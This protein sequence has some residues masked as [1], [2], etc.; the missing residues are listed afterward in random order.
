MPTVMRSGPYRFYYFSHEPNEPP[1]IHVDRDEATAKF[2]LNSVRL[3]SNLR[4]PAH[5][6]RKIER[7]IR[8]HH[9]ELLEAWDDHA[10]P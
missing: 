8:E 1:H 2:W 10:T 3:A 6:I 9:H 5:E 4:F 7:L